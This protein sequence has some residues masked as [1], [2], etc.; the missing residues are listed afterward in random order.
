M[1]KNVMDDPLNK[2][3]IDLLTFCNIP[4]KEKLAWLV[5]L[6]DMT[7]KEK[8]DLKKNLEEEAKYE[9]EAEEKE[10]KLILDAL[11]AKL[12]AQSNI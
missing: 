2:E 6:Q 11:N 7:E 5:V 4:A 3:I 10:G 8:L 1:N 12:D 9:V